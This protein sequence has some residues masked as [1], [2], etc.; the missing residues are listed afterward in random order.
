M[1][2]AAFSK[3]AK[4]P[5]CWTLVMLSKMSLVLSKKALKSTPCS[6]AIPSI[7]LRMP[8][9]SPSCFSSSSL[10]A[11]RPVT[12]LPSPSISSSR[13]P[14]KALNL[15]MES[16]RLT[17]KSEL[18]AAN[19]RPPSTM[20]QNSVRSPNPSLWKIDCQPAW[21]RRKRV[22]TDAM[23][24]R[25]TKYAFFGFSANNIMLVLLW[26]ASLTTFSGL[27]IAFF[28]SSS[29]FVSCVSSREAC[30]SNESSP[31]AAEGAKLSKL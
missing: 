19:Q 23:I 24:V 15:L 3:S 22:T 9:N 2:A 5:F 26:Q 1:S 10:V 28:L 31:M 21:N 8:S 27:T 4:S 17:W 6:V 29:F 18:M 12:S 7:S 14:F 30:E 11:C 16:W 25:P 13:R 20:A